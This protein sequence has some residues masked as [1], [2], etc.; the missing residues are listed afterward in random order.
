M[1]FLILHHYLIEEPKRIRKEEHQEKVR[2]MRQRKDLN[3]D[4]REDLC[5]IYYTK[6]FYARDYK[7]CLEH[8]PK[9]Q[10]IYK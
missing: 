2:M 3:V 1:S 4:R 9:E 7:E 5:E 10:D 8:C 6:C